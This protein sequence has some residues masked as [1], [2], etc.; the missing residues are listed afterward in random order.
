MS[1]KV[2]FVSQEITPFV[3]ENYMSRLGK[4]IPHLIQEEGN[5]IRAFHPKWGNINERRNQ[6]H[7][8]IRLS[9]MNIIIDETDHPLLIKVAS[10]PSTKMQVYFIDNEEKW[11]YIKKLFRTIRNICFNALDL[12]VAELPYTIEINNRKHM[13]KL[14]EEGLSEYND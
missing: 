13:A 1:K 10:L 12:N 4:T 5:E 9:G 7:E 8:V 11:E 14:L 3:P 2:L 6:L